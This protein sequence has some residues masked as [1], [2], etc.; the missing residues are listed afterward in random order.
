V[1]LDSL[2]HRPG[3]SSPRPA[4]YQGDIADGELIDRIFAEHPDIGAVIHCAALIVV[5]DSVADPVRYYR[6]N[7]AGSLDSPRTC[8]ATAARG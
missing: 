5:P 2:G 7:V 8:C 4:F 3:V 1:I 6:A